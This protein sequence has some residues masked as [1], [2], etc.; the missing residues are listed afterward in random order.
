MS[1]GLTIVLG[2]ALVWLT[3][4]EIAGY[5]MRAAGTEKLAQAAHASTPATRLEPGADVRVEGTI[6]EGPTT[7]APS[8]Q[9]P[10]LAA[11]TRVG[12]TAQYKDS[13]GKTQRS[14]ELVALRR[15][16]PA[17]IEIAVGEK[18][19]ELPLELWFP[20]DVESREMAELPERFGVTPDEIASA[21]QR[22]LHGPGGGFSVS[23]GTID[24]GTQV[25]VV[26]T[27]EQ[28]ADVLRLAPDRVLE[29]VLVYPGSQADYVNEVRGSGGG[30]RIAGWIFALGVGP[31]PLMIIG[32]V[33]LLRS[34]PQA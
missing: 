26:G 13:Q 33:L 22:L 28:R 14:Y 32:A 4:W 9:K 17:N 19:L 3:A 5:F 34:R 18:R 29:R 7:L 30:L 6:A 16:G 1:K 20:H 11:V 15:V 2:L 8:S 21:R 12:V 27:L 25:F 23:E 10:C 24:A 31:L